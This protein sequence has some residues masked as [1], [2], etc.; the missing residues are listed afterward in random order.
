MTKDVG[1]RIARHNAGKEKTTKPYVPFQLIYSE[2]CTGRV[3]ARQKE[4]YWKSGIGKQKLRQIRDQ[5]K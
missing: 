5:L 2:V 1:A 4:K 3:A